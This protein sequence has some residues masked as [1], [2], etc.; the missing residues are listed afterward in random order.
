VTAFPDKPENVFENFDRSTLKRK[1][2]RPAIRGQSM[3]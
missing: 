2:P 3:A 1:T